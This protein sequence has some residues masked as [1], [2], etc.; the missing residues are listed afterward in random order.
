M[1]A[2]TSESRAPLAVTDGDCPLKENSG[3]SAVPPSRALPL[4]IPLRPIPED[5]ASGARSSRSRSKEK[6]SAGLLPPRVAE[7]EPESVPDPLRAEKEDRLTFVPSFLIEA[8]REERPTPF[9]AALSA[10]MER[11]S[12]S[13]FTRS[14]PGRVETSRF[15]TLSFPRAER[16][17]EEATRLISGA[18]SL[19]EILAPAR[20]SPLRS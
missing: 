4:R 19:P 1:S 18:G 8:S 3:A 20:T 14:L 6:S 16:V 11:P 13:S 5:A 15:F 12:L 2:A 7:P 10:L 9:A 17:G